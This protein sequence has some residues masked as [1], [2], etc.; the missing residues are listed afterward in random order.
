MQV[1]YLSDIG[2]NKNN[3]EDSIGVFQNQFGYYFAVVADG[4]TSNR[5]GDVASAMV[6]KSL[7]NQWSESNVSSIVEAQHWIDE[8]AKTENQRISEASKK[9]KDLT[10]MATTFVA[11]VVIESQVLIANLGDSRAYKYDGEELKQLTFDHFLSN[12]LL[13]N[14]SV[15]PDEVPFVPN[16]NAVTRFFGTKGIPKVDYVELEILNDDIIMLSTDGLTKEVEET[17]I[18]RILRAKNKKS[19][20]EMTVQLVDFANNQSGFDNVSVLLMSNF[21]ENK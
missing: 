10:K 5:G 2:T 8:V 21:L 17:D 3:N 9:F 15:K 12:E 1:A 11:A 18:V 4:V 13:R 16:G 6:V 14:G 7:G 19:L 20:S